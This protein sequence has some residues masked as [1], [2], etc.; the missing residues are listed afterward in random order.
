MYL[1]KDVI[2]LKFN[3]KF[4]K[5]LVLADIINVITP[6]FFCWRHTKTGNSAFLCMAI[7]GVDFTSVYT[8]LRLDFGTVHTVLYIF[9]FHFIMNSNSRRQR[10]P[11]KHKYTQKY[12][13][14]TNSNFKVVNKHQEI[15]ENKNILIIQYLENSEWYMN[16]CN[17]TIHKHVYVVH[18]I[19]D[20]QIF[21]YKPLWIEDFIIKNHM[22]WH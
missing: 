8:Y 13:E 12:E 15:Y 10:E 6:L 7:R 16:T 22:T 9:V 19:P 3:F 2:I 11:T 14:E 5:K 18:F 4:Q 17:W 1:L 20:I 21:G